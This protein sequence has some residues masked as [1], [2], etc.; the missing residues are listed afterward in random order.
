MRNLATKQK[1]SD[2]ATQLAG[3]VLRVEG[4]VLFVRADGA[5]HEARRAASCLLEPVTGDRVLLAT[6]A[7]GSSYVLAVLERA[8]G[9]PATLSVE[10][11]CAIRLPNGQLSVA[12][13]KGVEFVSAGDI[14]MTSPAVEVK[15]VEGRFGLGRLTV[16]GKELFAEIATAK[17]T[18]GAL[19]IVAER[20]MQKVQR[21]YRFV[22]EMDQLRAKR[23]DYT[24]EKSMH[25]HG[26][27]TLMTA[28]SLVK[29]DGEHIH[30]G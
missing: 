15:A 7:D 14:S 27:N 8:E 3:Q 22:E 6:I 24:A 26:E 21:A 25:L 30:M 1:P 18:L 12:T 2:L 4:A 9:T 10:G 13:A 23:V 11:D 29:F 28:D 19:D 20:V 17:T 16:V 5:V